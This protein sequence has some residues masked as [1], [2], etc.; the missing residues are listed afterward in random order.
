M[1]VDQSGKFA[2]KS[3]LGPCKNQHSEAMKERFQT[4]PEKSKYQVRYL[5]DLHAMLKKLIDELD[6][7]AQQDKK[8]LSAG[9]TSCSR[10]TADTV[11]GGAIAR[12]M[13]IKEKM[14]AAERMAAE[15]DVE[16]SQKVMAE[17]EKLA[18]ERQHLNRV[19]EMADTWVDEVCDVCGRQISWRAPEEIEARKFGRRHPHE[20][21]II[22][23]G[24]LQARKAL[25]DIGEELKKLKSDGGGK[26]ER[27]GEGRDRERSRDRS[28]DRH[29][30]RRK[31][32]EAPKNGGEGSGDA[33]V[34]ERSRSPQR[35]AGTAERRD[36]GPSRGDEGRGRGEAR[37]QESPDRGD[38]RRDSSRGRD[39]RGADRRRESSAERRGANDRRRDDSRGDRRRGGDRDRG[40]DRSRSRGRDRRGGGRGG[41]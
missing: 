41:R 25:S 20:M 37:R 39:A 2:A 32:R 38:R 5:R 13:L 7:R 27:N 34:A 21:G 23:N 19:K 31:E 9:G 1:F 3:P 40:R 17:A 28:R 10:E 18:K 8:R 30:D 16:M 4:D 26:A 6:I 14:E 12:E 33:K 29:R 36:E 24:W 35:D 22:H 15:G 11:E